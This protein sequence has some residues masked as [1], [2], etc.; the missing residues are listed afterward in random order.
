MRPVTPIPRLP[1]LRP[2]LV[3]FPELGV[4]HV[5][6]PFLNSFQSYVFLLAFSL[7]S[8]PTVETEEL[9]SPIITVLLPASP[10]RSVNA[11][12]IIYLATLMSGAYIYSYLL[13]L[14][15]KGIL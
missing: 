9:K 1:P 11:L 7:N 14:P 5:L 8:L 3:R 13:Y 10:F 6:S 4:F 12:Y 2:P 15:G